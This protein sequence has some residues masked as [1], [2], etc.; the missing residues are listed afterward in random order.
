MKA[1]QF[2][3][4]LVLLGCSVGSTVSLAQGGVESFQAVMTLDT[5]RVQDVD[6]RYKAGA[7]GATVYFSP[8][9]HESAPYAESA[10]LSQTS[11][12]SYRYERNEF[13]ERFS[14]FSA[15]STENVLLARLVLN[16][17]LIVEAGYE[18]DEES[19]TLESYGLGVGY[20]VTPLSTVNV[21]WSNE[22]DA[23]ITT[24][25]ASYRVVKLHEGGSAIAFD[26]SYLDKEF[27]DRFH[28]RTLELEASYYASRALGFS[29][30]YFKQSA[31]GAS[32]DSDVLTFGVEYF[33][34]PKI[35]TG[36]SF[37]QVFG[38]D[39][40]GDRNAVFFEG[41]FRL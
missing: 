21:E 1:V 16:Q 23:D 34:T 10:F 24:V 28:A 8:I 41:E 33:V 4:T 3:G 2:A 31:N 27:F 13:T 26:A 32:F 38:E 12:V 11:A 40:A 9:T 19:T 15:D 17:G 30:S 5:A 35:A 36:V 14:D 18:H 7:V 37:A 25:G 20:Y 6:S 39:G 29:A 22:P